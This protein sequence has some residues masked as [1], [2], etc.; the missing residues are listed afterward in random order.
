VLS[1]PL[2]R[3]VVVQVGPA[4]SGSKL[5]A[6]GASTREKALRSYEIFKGRNCVSVREAPS[7]YMALLDYMRALGCRDAD[8]ARL[9]THSVSWRGAVYTARLSPAGS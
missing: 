7:A 5:S 9:G 3:L 2:G 4:R 8:V 1:Y 6:P